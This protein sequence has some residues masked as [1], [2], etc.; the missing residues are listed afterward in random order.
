VGGCEFATAAAVA[1]TNPRRAERAPIGAWWAFGSVSMITLFVLLSRA[2]VSIVAAAR[3]VGRL[4]TQSIEALIPESDD[5]HGTTGLCLHC[6]EPG[7]YERIPSP[8]TLT[9]DLG[10]GRS[11]QRLAL[12]T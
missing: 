5:A 11:A 3:P 12:D 8:L 4:N 2:T 9:S 10:K 7:C 1:P 6:L